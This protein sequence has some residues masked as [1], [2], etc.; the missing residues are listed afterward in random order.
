MKAA[1]ADS[2]FFVTGMLGKNVG[3]KELLLFER[4][5]SHNESP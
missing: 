2:F 1:A 5:Y 3:H 4:G